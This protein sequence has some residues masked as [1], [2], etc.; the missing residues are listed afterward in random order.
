MA[1]QKQKNRGISVVLDGDKIR[2]AV[3]GEEPIGVISGNSSVV[4]DGDVNQ[5]KN[6]HLRDDLARLY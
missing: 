1:T 6:K 3:A 2:E 4:G 5:W